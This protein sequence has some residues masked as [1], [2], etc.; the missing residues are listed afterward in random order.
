MNNLR[1]ISSFT[2]GTIYEKVIQDLLVPSLEHWCLPY[3]IF[4][5][6]NLGN[7]AA[8]SRQRPL[9]IKEAMEMFPGENILWVDADARILKY[10]DL[11]FHIPE[12]IHLGV[13]YLSWADHYGRPSDEDKTE[14]L[15][16]TSYY[17][18]C[19]EMI[20]FMEEWIERSVRA[21]RNH[22][23]TLDTMIK[24]QMD[25]NLQLFIIPREYCYIMTRPDGSEPYVPIKYPT[26]AHFQ[27]SRL[28]RHNLYDK[29]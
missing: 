27:A 13:N 21:E 11:L 9:Y 14:I 4:A 19:K 8:N 6:P 26:I 10:P 1:F 29:E 24:E 2:T 17:K 3:H 5:K 28:A 16:G 22:R 15:D 18:N 12:S 25:E 20:P 7:W 23:L